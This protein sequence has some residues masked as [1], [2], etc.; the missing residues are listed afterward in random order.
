MEDRAPK[1]LNKGISLKKFNIGLFVL[2]VIVTGVMFIVMKRTSDLYDETYDVSE[3]VVALRES[4]YDMQLASDYLT[5]QIRCFA[6]TGET[7][8]L[9][10]YFEEANVTKRREKALDTIKKYQSD[11]VAFNSLNE[12]MVGSLDLMNIEYYAA[13]LTI[14]AYGYDRQSF[15]D[16]PGNIELSKRDLDRSVEEKKHVAINML[17]DNAYRSKKEYI[18]SNMKKC[19]REISDGMEKE[20]SELAAELKAQVSLEHVLT[21][22]LLAILMGMV[23]ATTIMVINPLMKFVGLIREE[24]PIPIKGAYEVRFLAKTYNLIYYTNVENKKRLEYDASHD[25]LTGL[26]NRRGYDLLLSNVDLECAALLLVDLDYFKQINDK[27][28]H[29]VGDRELVRVAES[30][31]KAFR[32]HGYSCRLGGDEFAVILV[33]VDGKTETMVE[34]KIRKINERLSKSMKGVPAVSVSAGLAFS[35]EGMDTEELFKNADNAL[36]EVKE[37]GRGDICVHE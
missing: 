28:G 5:E 35:H 27:N 14:D 29:D 7:K 6:V 10:N 9:Y 11:T 34:K 19:L 23:I 12:A 22:L 25:K 21:E 16:I 26:F 24:K 32:S 37:K 31:I 13:L 2:A 20:Q 18:S 3:Q 36:Y 15:S 33:H 4:A 30:L 17:F 1:K 8:Y